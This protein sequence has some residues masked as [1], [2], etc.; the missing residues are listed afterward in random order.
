MKITVDGTEY[1]VPPMKFATLKKAF[2]VILRVSQS[3][4]PLELAV[5]AIEVV[6]LAMHKTHP[7]MT[8][9]WLEENLSIEETRDLADIITE[10]SI[11]S[12]LVT[13]EEAERIA[14]EGGAPSGEA[15][16]AAPSTATST[17]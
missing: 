16:G 14:A 3:T 1:E 2:P 11:E 15:A 8:P 5:G 13:R 12:G 7:E 17:Q 4:D 6:S 10:I 9:E